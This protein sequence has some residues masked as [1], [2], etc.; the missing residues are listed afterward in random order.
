VLGRGVSWRHLF[1]CKGR[2]ARSGKGWE[3]ATGTFWSLP[4]E[5]WLEKAD[6]ALTPQVTPPF[7]FNLI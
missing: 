7:V 3:R 4:R 2:T 6:V 1:E 5:Q